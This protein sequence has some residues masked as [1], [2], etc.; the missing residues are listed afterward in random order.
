MIRT[1]FTR[2]ALIASILMI[3]Y[4]FTLAV[5]DVFDLRY[6]PLLKSRIFT[7]IMQFV[8]FFGYW[9]IPVLVLMSLLFLLPD[10]KAYKY[11]ILGLVAALLFAW[12]II[13]LGDG[14]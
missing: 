3:G 9:N 5:W 8:F 14:I 11:G 10:K 12:H 4:L 1:I 7:S 2:Y 13:K 6:E